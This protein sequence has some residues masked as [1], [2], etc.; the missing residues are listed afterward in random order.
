MEARQD[1]VRGFIHPQDPKSKPMD[2]NLI[3]MATK[4][5]ESAQLDLFGTSKGFYICSCGVLGYD[6]H[7]TPLGRTTNDLLVHYFEDHQDEIYKKVF[8]QIKFP[9]LI[10]PLH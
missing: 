10:P 4:V 8:H 5:F 2:T 7:H 3:E 6:N 9:Q 1:R